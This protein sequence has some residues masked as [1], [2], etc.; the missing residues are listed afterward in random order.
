M[1]DSRTAF[2]VLDDLVH[3]RHSERVAFDPQEPP[4]ERDVR[5][6]LESARWAPTV[7]NMQNFEIVVVDA[8]E[9]LDAIGR[10]RGSASEEFVKEHRAQLSYSEEELEARGTGLLA[11][12]PASWPTG[13]GSGNEVAEGGYGYLGEAVGASPVIM[14]V[15]YDPSKRAPASK[16]DFLGIMSLGCVME[17]MWLTAEALGISLQ[18]MSVFG[19]PKVE[20]ELRGILAVPEPVR[21][22]F[23]CRIGYRAESEHLPRVRRQVDRFVHRNRYGAAW[24]PQ[25]L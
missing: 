23:A 2:E 7:H 20:G 22:A 8:P 13:Y 6:I 21:I 4:A 19:D 5:A 16:G 1:T 24:V 15:L 3:R 14:V 18:I 17:N 10:V 12:T 25:S 9:V 11:T